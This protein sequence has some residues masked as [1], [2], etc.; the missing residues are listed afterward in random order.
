MALTDTAIRSTK[1]ELKPF[2]MYDRNGLFLLV[3]PSGSKLWRC[4][5]RFDGK[6]KL[7]ALGEY[8]V[9]GL[10]QAR[11]LHLA[12]RRTLIAGLD[13]MAERKSKAEAKQR[14]AD[15]RQRE[16][17]KSFERIA[18]RWWDWWAIGKSLRHADTVMRRL[19]LTFSPHMA[20]SS[21]TR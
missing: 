21:L 15:M 5:Y 10:A 11:E 12:T 17:E 3:N 2:K 7:M 13:P 8:P 9:V 4:R 1:P 19:K 14:E 6:E 18:R 20:T 16:A